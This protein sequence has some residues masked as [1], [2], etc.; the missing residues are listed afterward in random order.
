MEKKQITG[1]EPAQPIGALSFAD[2]FIQ[3]DG[4]CDTDC[5][6]VVWED[7]LCMYRNDCPIGCGTVWVMPIPII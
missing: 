4:Y 7:D 3:G 6:A 5:K 2:G 1:N